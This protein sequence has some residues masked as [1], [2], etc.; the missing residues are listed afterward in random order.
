M[1]YIFFF[2]SF[3]FSSIAASAQINPA[4]SSVQVISY[5]D[6]NESQNYTIHEERMS[7]KG[8]DTTSYLI[9]KYDVEITVTDSSES[10]YLISWHF[11]NVESGPGNKENKVHD[12]MMKGLTFKYY[13]DEFGSLRKIINTQEVKE[14]LIKKVD[15]LEKLNDISLSYQA[16]ADRIEKNTREKINQF[17]EFHGSELI[18]KETYE[19]ESELAGYDK[20]DE[21]LVTTYLWL[22]DVDMED[23]TYILQKEQKAD[24]ELL[25]KIFPK[26]SIKDPAYTT[27]LASRI[28]D[29]GWLIYSIRE[30][31]QKTAEY[32]RTE[33]TIIELE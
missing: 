1:R 26:N 4:D 10:S 2:S 8:T 33:K 11:Q 9:I 3:I 29:S 25:K 24:E 21:M 23:Y 18:Y 15:S 5:W 16:L 22:D 7:L 17:H 14:A 28:H 13:T 19:F 27:W 12:S 20:E 32:T 30:I 31:E 6:L